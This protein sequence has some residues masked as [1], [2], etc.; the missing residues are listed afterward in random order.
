M[1]YTY[2]I[3]QVLVSVTGDKDNVLAT[4][5]ID[6]KNYAFIGTEAEAQEWARNLNRAFAM[7]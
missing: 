5:K 2:D 3:G 4:T 1:T 6:G 7:A